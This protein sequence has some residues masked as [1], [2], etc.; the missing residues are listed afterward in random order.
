VLLVS[1]WG[2]HGLL[3]SLGLPFLRQ[4]LDLPAR[5]K[6]LLTVHDHLWFGQE[7][8]DTPWPRL[9]QTLTGE[10]IRI[11]GPWEDWIPYLTAADV[12][13]ID[14][15]SLA[16]HYS[17]LQRPAI[18]IPVPKQVMTK[19]ALIGTFR[20]A[21]EP[22]AEGVPLDASICAAMHNYDRQRFA[23]HLSDVTS[24]P[25]VAAG[26]TRNAVHRLLDLSRG[27]GIGAREEES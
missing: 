19:G 21:C 23:R 24:Y 6:V 26:R 2:P 8:K 27:T 15:S 14:Y 13:I 25:G 9:L 18:A 11:R 20:S 5:Y 7:G 22:L 1:T 17:L 16:L 12:A 4:T 10:R 3:E